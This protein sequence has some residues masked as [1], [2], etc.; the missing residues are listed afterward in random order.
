MKQKYQVNFKS[1]T[2]PID[3]YLL[4]RENKNSD[5][6]IVNVYLY[7]NKSMLNLFTCFV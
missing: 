1:E 5:G 4:N 2:E 3:V 6:K 7:N